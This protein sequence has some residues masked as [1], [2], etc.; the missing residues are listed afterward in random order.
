MKKILNIKLL[1]IILNLTVISAFFMPNIFSENFTNPDSPCNQIEVKLESD[2]LNL[3]PNDEFGVNLLFLLN[4]MN[5]L[6]LEIPKNQND[7]LDDDFKENSEEVLNENSGESSEKNFEK[8]SVEKILSIKSFDIKLTFDNK[9]LSFK[10]LQ[11]KF[12][13]NLKAKAK[14][15]EINIK[16]A[17]KRNDNIELLD[18]NTLLTE[19]RFKVKKN[20]NI[21]N[22]LVLIK[23]EEFLGDDSK[24]IFSKIGDGLNL[25]IENNPCLLES[26]IPNCGELAPAFVPTLFNYEM[27]VESGVSEIEFDTAAQDSDVTTKINRYNLNSAGKTT[28]LKITVSNSETGGNS[29]YTIN[30]N[31]K[32]KIFV[33][34]N[35]SSAT[36]NDKR[37]NTKKTLKSSNISNYGGDLKNNLEI[38]FSKPE[39]A[40]QKFKIK[41]N[42]KNNSKN[43]TSRSKNKLNTKNKRRCS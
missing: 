21:G 18:E 13:K 26:I 33:P 9:N 38:D 42:L 29:V 23:S 5:T 34:K 30:V 10:G 27:E 41:S 24:K 28:I 4:Q 43:T 31:R 7:V 37:I 6:E 14:H 17:P 32:K 15:S 20:A 22:S 2:S 16:F 3:K 40:F 8:K 11:N 12:H 35:K 25:K 36:D 1:S 19:I 39:N